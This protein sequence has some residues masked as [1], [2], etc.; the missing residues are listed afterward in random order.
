MIRVQDSEESV[1]TIR[2]LSMGY[3]PNDNRIGKEKE[4]E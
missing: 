3:L 2:A 4:K 1:D